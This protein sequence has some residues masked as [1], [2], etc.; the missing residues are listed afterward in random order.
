L[1]QR[2]AAARSRCAAAIAERAD[3]SFL[4]LGKVADDKVLVHDPVDGR[5]N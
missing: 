3:G 1:S 5:L 2:L 4:I